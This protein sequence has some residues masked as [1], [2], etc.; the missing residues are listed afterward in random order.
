MPVNI[1][2]LIVVAGLSGLVFLWLYQAKVLPV[3][4]QELRRW[5][6]AWLL[7]TTA[8]FLVPNYWLFMLVL[9]VICFAAAS[10]APDRKLAFYFFLLPAMPM[11]QQQVP[12]FGLV[13]YLFTLN[14]ARLLSFVVLLPLV[15]SVTMGTKAKRIHSL[16]TDKYIA[17]YCLVAFALSFRSTTLTDSFRTLFNLLLDI[18][19]PYFAVTRGVV[20]KEG[21]VRVFAAIAASGAALAVIGIFESI[22]G[23]IVYGPLAANPPGS[24]ISHYMFRAGFMR[25]ATTIVH[26]ILYGY[27]QMICL[28][29][30]LAIK[31]LIK[32]KVIQLALAGLFLLAV[33]C[34]FS[35]GP[36]V[37]AAV[38]LLVYAYLAR[39]SL[40]ALAPLLMGAFLVLGVMSMT[41]VGQQILDYLPFIG[42]VREDTIGYRQQLLANGLD[43]FWRSPLFGSSTFMQTNEMEAMRQGEGIIDIVNA[44]L[45]EG[46]TYG[47]AGLIPFVGLPLSAL[48]QLWKTMKSSKR[49][50]PAWHQIHRALFATI[51]GMVVV[52][53]TTS[54]G[55]RAL[56]Y[57]W[58]VAGLASASCYAYRRENATAKAEKDTMAQLVPKRV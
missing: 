40:A 9:G 51:V 32:P 36:W 27:F 34:S 16:P 50:D 22:K 58:C 26:P 54:T 21:F 6:V 2:A 55:D 37:G 47:F 24:L 17:A 12:A 31:P 42:S 48:W 4:A 38:V 35:R 39:N 28:G 49:R 1:R 3:R 19:L 45:G 14:Y 29:C 15:L 30:L 53:V 44:Y 56:Q 7:V 57:Y 18:A 25:A 52:F 13:N 5:G 11:M 33:L 46:L 10:K 20:T 23:W 8:G 41:S 43:V